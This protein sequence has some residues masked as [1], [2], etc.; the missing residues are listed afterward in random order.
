LELIMQSVY[1]IWVVN[2]VF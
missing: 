1:S 2:P